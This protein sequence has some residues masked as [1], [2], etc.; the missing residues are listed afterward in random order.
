MLGV[1]GPTARLS[2]HP[3]ASRTFAQPSLADAPPEADGGV[4]EVVNDVQ[5]HRGAEAQLGRPAVDRLAN[6]LSSLRFHG[7]L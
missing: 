7:T 1:R 3:P 2:P 5:L 6:G 4:D